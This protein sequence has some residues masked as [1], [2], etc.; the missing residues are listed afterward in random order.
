MSPKSSC[1]PSLAGKWV[2]SNYPSIDWS[3][4]TLHMASGVNRIWPVATQYE[5]TGAHQVLN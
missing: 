4:G 1:Y 3:N 5:M 2:Y